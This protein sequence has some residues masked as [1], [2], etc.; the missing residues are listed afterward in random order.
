MLP[1]LSECTGTR[2]FG[3]YPLLIALPDPKPTIPAA[4]S[5]LPVNVL[6]L[7]VTSV[8][9]VTD[10]TIVT[11]VTIGVNSFVCAPCAK[12]M[13]DPPKTEDWNIRKF[14]LELKRKCQGRAKEEKK[15]DPRWLAEILC[16]ALGFSEESYLDPVYRADAVLNSPHESG[17]RSVRRGSPPDAPKTPAGNLRNKGPRKGPPKA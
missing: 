1:S 11:G 15:T 4:C 13:S 6:F 14:P 5:V 9:C 8:T 12:R 17:Q 7:L 3:E 10:V 2:T 16:R